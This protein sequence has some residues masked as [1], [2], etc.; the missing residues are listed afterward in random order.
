MDLVPIFSLL[1]LLIYL[2]VESYLHQRRLKKISGRI[3][4]TGIRGKSS[5]TRLIVAGL[6]PSGF[7]VMAK[8]TGSR[9]VLIYPDSLEKE[10]VRRGRANILEQKKLIKEARLRRA[11]L[12]VSEMMSIQPECLKTENKH[13][14]KPGLLVVS[15]FRVDHTEFLGEDKEQIARS[16][17]ETI[18]SGQLVFIPEEETRPWMKSVALKKGFELIPVQESQESTS[19]VE[20]LPY[21]EFEANVRLALSVLKHF[22]VSLEKI[23]AGWSELQPDYGSPRA[24]KI[25]C[26]DNKIIYFVSLFAANDPESSF[27]AL[28]LIIQ[29]KGWQKVPKIGLLS[30]RADRGDR[31]RQWADFL[32]QPHDSYFDSLALIGPGAR[33]LKRRLQKGWSS[34][35]GDGWLLTVRKPEDCLGKIMSLITENREDLVK[36]NSE[37]VI[38]GLGNIVGFGQDLIDYLERTSNAIRI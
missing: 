35:E 20:M 5:I 25:S 32:S 29:K 26:K 15:N 4:V 36:E 37:V 1:I 3:A 31:T 30:L 7:E 11:N 23:K 13:L 21:P 6:R 22:S 24:W 12:L 28:E 9:P 27:I 14:L 18:P 10:I 16:V 2:G 8:T 19:L 17:L 38:F 34:P 33:A